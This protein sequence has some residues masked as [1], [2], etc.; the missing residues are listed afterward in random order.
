MKRK[1]AKATKKNYLNLPDWP[2]VPLP[3]YSNEEAFLLSI[4][5]AHDILPVIGLQPWLDRQKH[6][7]PNRF[8]L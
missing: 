5:H 3:E 2:D 7:N 4:R 1:P 6:M 8:E